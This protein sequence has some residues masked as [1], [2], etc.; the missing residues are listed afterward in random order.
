MSMNKD[1][2]I[3]VVGSGAMG[4]GIAQVVA[5]AGH[6]VVVYDNNTSALERGK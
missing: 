4:S 3:G 5:T 1:L 6:V 2:V